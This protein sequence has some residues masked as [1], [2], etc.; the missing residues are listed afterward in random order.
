MKELLNM[1]IDK[2]VE[3]LMNGELSIE[4]RELVLALW[5]RILIQLEDIK[6]LV[7]NLY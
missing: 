3:K 7:V 5:I 6:N 4:D 1:S 2:L